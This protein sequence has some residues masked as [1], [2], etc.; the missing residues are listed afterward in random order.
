MQVGA[1][2][3]I[4]VTSAYHLNAKKIKQSASVIELNASDGI[5]LKCGGNI[6]TVDASGIHFNSANVDS[7]SANAGVSA[8]DIVQPEIK[9]P[10][11]NKLRVI[12]MS[13]SVEKQDDITQELVYT[14]KVEK[15]EN[16]A[17]SETTELTQTQKAQINWLF[18][19]N[20]DEADKDIITDNPTDDTLSIDG[21]EMRVTIEDENLYKYG[22]AHAFVV[23]ADEEEGYSM[24]ELKRSID[25][26]RV[27]GKNLI[28]EN[29]TQL[30]YKVELNIQ[31][32]TQE[33][34][35][36][37]KAEIDARDKENKH[38]QETLEVNENLEI[39]YT[40]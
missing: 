29:D 33:E 1:E 18:I 27:D 3:G 2:L 4:E 24:S 31:A 19:K 39:I 23:D 22:H 10:L 17:W 35:K 15:F 37:L 36:T 26:I 38:K 6:L 40:H 16:G 11:Y 25:V 7:N 20:N 14:A 34:L 9:K 13:T 30:I 32:P 21:L 8:N 28:D 12:G 5:S